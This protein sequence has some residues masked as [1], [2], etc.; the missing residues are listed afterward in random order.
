MKILSWLW[1]ELTILWLRAEVNNALQSPAPNVELVSA[2]I[3]S[4][5]AARKQRPA[6]Q[7]RYID[8]RRLARARKS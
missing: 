4:L 2:L 6:W 7:T 3:D 8:A 1:N 5:H